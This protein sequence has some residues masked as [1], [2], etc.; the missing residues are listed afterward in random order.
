MKRLVLIF[1]VL[2]S[3]LFAYALSGEVIITN[4]TVKHHSKTDDGSAVYYKLAAKQ[5]IRIVNEKINFF[6]TEKNAED[7]FYYEDGTL[8]LSD[9]QLHFKKA[10][11]YNGNLIL[12]QVFGEIEGEKFQS[13]R[14][15]LVVNQYQLKASKIIFST[16]EMIKIKRQY[17]HTV[18]KYLHE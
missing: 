16:P 15:T 1:I 2:F 10:F 9:S 6:I 14:I 18:S 13:K 11:F 12:K 3:P 4:I 17:Q 7:K 5:N 8:Y